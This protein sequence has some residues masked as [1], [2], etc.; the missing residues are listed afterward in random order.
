MI[1]PRLGVFHTTCTL[2]SII[3]KRFQD[4]GLRDLRVKAGIL[5]ADGSDTRAVRV[6]VWKG[7]LHWL[8]T[9]HS[10]DIILLEETAILADILSGDMSQASPHAMIE[11]ESYEDTTGLFDVYL[12]NLIHIANGPLSNFWMSTHGRVDD[13][14]AD[15]GI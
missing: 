2:I 1:I 8:E 5:L 12:N 6:L 4:A 7:F 3:G 15:S 9:N 14:R 13:A 10:K 11:N